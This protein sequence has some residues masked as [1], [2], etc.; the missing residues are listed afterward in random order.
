MK[1][2]ICHFVRPCGRLCVR[3]TLGVSFCQGIG[4]M[5][6]RRDWKKSPRR[7]SQCVKWTCEGPDAINSLS[8]LTS[9]F[10]RSIAGSPDRPIVRS[11]DRFI[12]RSLD[13]PIARSPASS[14]KR[15]HDRWIAGSTAGSL[16]RPLDRLISLDSLIAR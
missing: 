8:L 9:F 7:I 4:S 3:K 10:D 15:P 1:R 13:R 16:D 12:A 5:L 14:I 2:C 6:E 11:L